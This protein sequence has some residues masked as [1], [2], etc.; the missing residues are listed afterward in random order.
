MNRPS[1]PLVQ[2]NG[3]NRSELD[4]V[5]GELAQRVRAIE[6]ELRRAGPVGVPAVLAAN[7]AQ[8]YAAMAAVGD[9]VIDFLAAEPP[10]AEVRAVKD[11]I[12]SQIRDWARTGQFF[13]RV[14]ERAHG[15][16]GAFTAL[17]ILYDGQPA[18]GT[19]AALIFDDYYLQVISAR[20][21]RNRLD[22]L[23][24]HLG[25]EVR[26]RIDAG[27]KSVRILSLGSGAARELALLV[28]D[29]A[30]SAAAA[31][32]CV[33][34]D[35]DALRYVRCRLA[36]RLRNRVTYRLARPADFARRPDRPSRPYH[37]IY[38]AEQFNLLDDNQAAQMVHDCFEHLMPGGLLL[39]GNLCSEL[40]ANE[41]VLNEWVLDWRPNRRAAADLQ[42]I[43]ART[44]LGGAA[45]AIEHEPLHGYIFALARRPLSATLSP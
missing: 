18:G 32:T 43:F 25:N 21:T 28:D 23:V 9:W 7:R 17:E 27:L 38:A 29:P 22:Y 45:L 30:F 2:G 36:D 39:V 15:A 37:V 10:E 41:R 42:R 12:V 14:Y 16:S 5:L 35:P 11:R 8:V 4:V 13:H 34:A 6:A 33:D 31:V 1:T 3:G 40:P 20:A 44:P 24:Q 26:A 19:L